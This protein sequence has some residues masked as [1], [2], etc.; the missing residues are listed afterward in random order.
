MLFCKWS[1]YLMPVIIIMFSITASVSAKVFVKKIPK[2]LIF[3]SSMKHYQLLFI[4]QGWAALEQYSP[5]KSAVVSW[6]DLNKH[7]TVYLN[8]IWSLWMVCIIVLCLAFG[9]GHR[10]RLREL[11]QFLSPLPLMNAFDAICCKMPKKGSI[12]ELFLTN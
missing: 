8:P 12:I 6:V 10:I 3:F 7:C 5:C 4:K 11:N 9:V 1:F 2:K